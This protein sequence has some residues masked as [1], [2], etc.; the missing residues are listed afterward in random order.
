MAFS[1]CTI[2]N[3]GIYSIIRFFVLCVTFGATLLSSAA[4]PLSLLPKPP[5][6]RLKRGS[7]LAAVI[8]DL[9][10]SIPNK[11]LL[12]LIIT[13][14][15]NVHKINAYRQRQSVATANNGF[16][17]RLSHLFATIWALLSLVARRGTLILRSTFSSKSKDQSSILPQH[18]QS[19]TRADDS[20]ERVVTV[21][22]TAPSASNA[23]G[24]PIQTP[25]RAVSPTNNN[26]KRDLRSSR[27]ASPTTARFLTTLNDL[28]AQMKNHQFYD[29]ER[30]LEDMDNHMAQMFDFAWMPGK[31]PVSFVPASV[32]S[33]PGSP[34]RVMLP[35]APPPIRRDGKTIQILPIICEV[36]ENSP[37]LNRTPP[38]DHNRWSIVT[39]QPLWGPRAY[40]GMAY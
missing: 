14:R 7:N 29:L 26:S 16:L 25:A 2:N 39:F 11:A 32:P 20:V 18:I 28:E 35:Q 9:W 30:E 33:P 12:M 37:D 22:P 21:S 24:N 1:R 17:S 38:Y 31:T 3:K 15:P 40:A 19:G 34:V 13:P 23:S 36:S 5:L 4:K 10:N 27:S 8:R 6:H